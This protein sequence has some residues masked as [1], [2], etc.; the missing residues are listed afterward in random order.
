MESM[1]YIPGVGNH[2]N[3]NGFHTLQQREQSNS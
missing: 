2:N 3:D 1:W